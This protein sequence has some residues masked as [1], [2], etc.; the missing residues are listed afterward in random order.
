MTKIQLN[1]GNKN[2]R[3]K[4]NTFLVEFNRLIRKNDK[5]KREQNGKKLK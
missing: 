2:V 1:Q 5:N 3:K 4:K